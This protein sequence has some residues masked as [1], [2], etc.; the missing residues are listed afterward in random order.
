MREEQERVDGAAVV[1]G[2]VPQYG[3]DDGLGGAGGAELEPEC[4][5]PIG[6]VSD[7]AG[8][9]EAREREKMDPEKGLDYGWPIDAM[10]IIVE[11][12]EVEKGGFVVVVVELMEIVAAKA[13][14]VDS[15]AVEIARIVVANVESGNGKWDGNV[16]EDL[17][18]C[19]KAVV[20]DGRKGGID[21]DGI[22]VLLDGGCDGDYGAGY[23]AGC[24][25]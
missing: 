11:R 15:A 17:V 5:E 14:A 4:D 13:E 3:D 22:G 16:E 23:D 10:E 24:D 18:V 20:V 7:A 9:D 12:Q 21:G 2:S 25:E 6:D 8:G 1:A 19:A